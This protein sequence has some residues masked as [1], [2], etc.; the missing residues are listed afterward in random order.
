MPAVTNKTLL[1]CIDNIKNT[2]TIIVQDAVSNA[3]AEALTTSNAQIAE[4]KSIL[5]E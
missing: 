5:I 4:L 1:E 2:I 3:V